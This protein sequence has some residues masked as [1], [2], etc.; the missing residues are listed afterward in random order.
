MPLDGKMTDVEETVVD[1]GPEPEP[2]LPVNEEKIPRMTSLPLLKGEEENSHMCK[3]TWA[4]LAWLVVFVLFVLTFVAIRENGLFCG[5]E[6][7]NITKVRQGQMIEMANFSAPA[8]TDFWSHACGHYVQTHLNNSVLSRMYQS[9]IA[10]MHSDLSD[11]ADYYVAPTQAMIDTMNTT[12]A[13]LAEMGYFSHYDFDI[14]PDYNNPLQYA[15]Y[16]ASDTSEIV[17]LTDFVPLETTALECASTSL[18]TLLSK[19]NTVSQY[20]YVKEG[21]CTSTTHVD[22]LVSDMS[23]L[24]LIGQLLKFWPYRLSE[25]FHTSYNLG[26]NISGLVEQVR[27]KVISFVNGKAWW[28]DDISKEKAVKKLKALHFQLGYGPSMGG[29]CSD[30]TEQVTYLECLSRGFQARLQKLTSIP[31]A[32]NA[33]DMNGL[34][35]NAYYSPLF[36]AIY[37]PDGITGFPLYDIG[38]AADDNLVGLGAIVAHEL[39]HVIDPQGINYDDRGAYN[40]W[41]SQPA[42]LNLEKVKSCIVD[43]YGDVG[44]DNATLTLNENFADLMAISAVFETPTEALEKLFTLWGQTWC[45]VSVHVATGAIPKNTDVHARSKYRVLGMVT[46]S[47][48]F[49]QTFSCEQQHLCLQKA[50]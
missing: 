46:Q 4:L 32:A 33:W 38:L 27:S 43:L 23:S 30:G 12:D 37:I 11:L 19:Y 34:E 3:F 7:N 45:Q 24:S 17:H 29:D 42:M 20:M 1:Y 6:M 8:C 39:G 44:V 13:T 18:L 25:R 49:S 14:F 9:N 15:I 2:L 31:D 47:T 26:K 36:N 40:P 48:A 21:N 5:P 22:K 16:V 10:L 35:A 50:N 41:M 28:L